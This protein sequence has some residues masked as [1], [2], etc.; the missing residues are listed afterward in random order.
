MFRTFFR[1]IRTLG[2]F[3]EDYQLIA[4]PSRHKRDNTWITVQT[5][6]CTGG[7][8]SLIIKYVLIVKRLIVTISP[9]GG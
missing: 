8:I 3:Y 2:A 4:L 6:F 7:A 1:Y 9:K 5:K